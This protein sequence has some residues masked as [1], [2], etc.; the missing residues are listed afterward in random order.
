MAEEFTLNTGYKIPMIGLGTYLIKGTDFTDKVVD[1]ALGAGYR[2]FDTA[3]MY[4][5]EKYLGAAFKKMLEKHN[6]KREDIFITT[7]FVPSTDYKTEEDY[8]KLV[9]ESLKNLQVDYLD[10]MLLHWPGVYGLSNRSKDVITYRHNAWKALSKFK[11]Q[12]L[13]RS[14]GVSNFLIRHLE[15]LKKECEVIP[16]LNQVEYH[17]LC[18]DLELLDYCKKNG[19]LLQAYSSLGTS[20]DRSLR[21][22]SVVKDVAKELDKST[23]QVLLRW[24]ILR[25]VAIIPKASS[26]DH[27]VDNMNLDFDIPKNLMDTLDNMG[28][29]RLDWNPH[30][31]I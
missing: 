27:L 6:L 21:N 28:E 3:H 1:E 8:H 30:D 29:E 14:I 22:H 16:A 15:E 31:V 9:Q 25:D 5:N 12:G 24:A 18:F 20:G 7:K 11:E 13:I 2:L 23:S 4:N 10:M 19:I 17:P 26:R